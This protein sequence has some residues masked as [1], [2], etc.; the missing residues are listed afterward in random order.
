MPLFSLPQRADLEGQ[1]CRSLTVYM[2]CRP[3]KNIWHGSDPSGRRLMESYCETWRTEATGA[4]GQAS[5]L[6]SGRLLEQKAASCQNT[7]IVLCIENSFMT[8]FSK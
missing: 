3:Q 2:P 5:S 1:G 6:L 8:S 7:Y 4:T